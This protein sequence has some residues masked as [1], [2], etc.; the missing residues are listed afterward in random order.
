MIPAGIHLFVTRY[1]LDRSCLRFAWAR[2]QV[3]QSAFRGFTQRRR[4]SFRPADRMELSKKKLTGIAGHAC[5]PF[6]RSLFLS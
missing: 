2:K 6:C 4:G 1:L 3:S 5:D